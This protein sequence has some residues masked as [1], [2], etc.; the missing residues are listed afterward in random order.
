MLSSWWLLHKGL[1]GFYSFI[2]LKRNALSILKDVV[3]WIKSS[4]KFHSLNLRSTDFLNKPGLQKPTWAK[5]EVLANSSLTVQPPRLVQPTLETWDFWWWDA[6]IQAMQSF[7][8]WKGYSCSE[9]STF[10][11]LSQ[12]ILGFACCRKGSTTRTALLICVSQIN[13]PISR[14]VK[15]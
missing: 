15:Q 9:T 2:P 3:L 12:S 10:G 5:S 4:A 6:F 7:P 1:K 14:Q 8:P 11:G 13:V